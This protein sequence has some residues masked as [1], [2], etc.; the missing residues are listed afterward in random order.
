MAAATAIMKDYESPTMK[1]I[2]YC[3][4][5]YVQMRYSGFAGRALPFEGDCNC[6]RPC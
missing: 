4:P 6:A 1:H 2:G 3:V 5:Y